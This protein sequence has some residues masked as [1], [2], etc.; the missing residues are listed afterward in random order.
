MAVDTALGHLR[1]PLLTASTAT[2]DQRASKRWQQ[3][4]AKVF[5]RFGWRA[6]PPMAGIVH[7]QDPAGMCGSPGD[8]FVTVGRDEL[9]TRLEAIMSSEFEAKLLGRVGQ[10][11]LPDINFLNEEEAS[12][13][14][15]GRTENVEEPSQLLGLTS[16]GAATW[17]K[18]PR[19]RR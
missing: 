5:K 10:G 17:T 15:N 7:L 13:S 3:Q 9:L 1:R 6:N 8:D 4:Y 2:A 16:D 14:W 18:A 19:K 11:H 12:F